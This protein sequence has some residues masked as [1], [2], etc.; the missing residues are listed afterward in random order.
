[1]E[2]ASVAIVVVGGG[3]IGHGGGVGNIGQLDVSEVESN[4][5]FNSYDFRSA[6]LWQ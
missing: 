6:Y 2:S 3:V 5:N 1:V 4:I